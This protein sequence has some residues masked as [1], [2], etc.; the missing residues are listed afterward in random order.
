MKIRH[1]LYLAFLL[2]G[3]QTFGQK[4]DSIREEKVREERISDDNITPRHAVKFS[5]LHLIGFYPTI[6]LGYEFRISGPFTMQLEGGY[7]YD[8]Y[9]DTYRDKRGFK[10]KVEP[11]LH[12]FQNARRTLSLYAAME[13]YYNHVDFDRD[14]T[15]TLCFDEDCQDQ[16]NQTFHYTT[17]YREHGLVFKFGFQKMWD[18]FIMDINTG[19]GIRNINYDEPE[20]PQGAFDED[21]LVEWGSFDIPRIEDRTIPAPFMG[22]R[23]GYMIR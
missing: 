16:Y 7:V 9:D 20:L 10:A 5:P 6:Q 14:K 1:Y 11:R 23:I 8:L 21:D 12:F 3:S 17:K 2:I 13:L 4:A 19:L 15:I 22:F 18:R